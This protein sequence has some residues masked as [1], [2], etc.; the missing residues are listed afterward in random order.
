MSVET[1]PAPVTE[2]PVLDLTKGVKTLGRKG[3]KNEGKA[4]GT[5]Y[6]FGDQSLPFS[7]LKSY[8][9]RTMGMTSR[10]ATAH[11]NQMLRTQDEKAVRLASLAVFNQRM[12]D[13]GLVP[14]FAKTSHSPDNPGNVKAA[15]VRWRRPTQPRASKADAELEQARAEAEKARAELAELKALVAAMQKA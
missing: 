12:T 5:S 11:V 3:S 15:A 14:D 7:D 10:Q 4:I 8:Y 6:G 1:I 2:A 13:L 9:Q